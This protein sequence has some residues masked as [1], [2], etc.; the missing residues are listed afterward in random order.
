MSPTCV[1]PAFV[2]CFNYDSM[3]WRGM[4][5]QFTGGGSGGGPGPGVSREASLPCMPW[6]APGRQGARARLWGASIDSWGEF[7]GR[8]GGGGGATLWSREGASLYQR[9]A[10]FVIMGELISGEF[11][12]GRVDWHAYK[13]KKQQ[14]INVLRTCDMYSDHNSYA[15]WL[16]VA[17][18]RDWL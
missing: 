11:A 2:I 14:D 16:I 5:Q 3:S 10:E 15:C 12:R 4:R 9:W 8:W 18:K 17:R 1:H 13:Q 7:V 6:R